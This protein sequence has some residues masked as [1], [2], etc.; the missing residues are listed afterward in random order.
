MKKGTDVNPPRGDGE[1]ALRRLL[2]SLLTFSNMR[3]MHFGPYTL[4]PKAYNLLK[5]SNIYAR[6]SF[7]G[8]PFT[9][10][11]KNS[12]EFPLLSQT[13]KKNPENISRICP[14]TL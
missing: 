14:K 5:K 7:V 13:C 9:Q 8:L 3:E 10:F 1:W 2:K 11:C 4:D 6:G 12:L